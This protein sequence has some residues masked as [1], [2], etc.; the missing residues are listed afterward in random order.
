MLDFKKYTQNLPFAYDTSSLF[1][2]WI[3]MLMVFLASLTIAGSLAVNNMVKYWNSSISGSLTVQV[4]PSSVKTSENIVDNTMAEVDR[5]VA[6]LKQTPGITDVHV[7]NNDEIG[8]LLEPWLGNIALHE[9]LP[10][11]RLIDVKINIPENLNLPKLKDELAKYAPNASLDVHRI[12]LAKLISLASTLKF[13]AWMVLLLVLITT[14]ITVIYAT[15]TSLEVHK[16]AIELLHLIGAR[17]AYIALLFSRRTLTF[18]L[19]GAFIGTFLALPLI[20]IIGT[21]LSGLQEGLLAR[22]SLA[23]FQWFFIASIPIFAAVLSAVTA[24]LTVACQLKRT[25]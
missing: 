8:K 2:P 16:P 23:W 24:F 21:M 17:D 11:P 7:L 9:D 15:F 1:L 25:M 22:A 5:T 13:L 4:M 19:A 3:M 14:A 12:W 6:V 18:S 10:V 20:I